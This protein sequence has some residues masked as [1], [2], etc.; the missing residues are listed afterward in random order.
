MLR[1]ASIVTLGLAVA[2][3]PGISVAAEE[4]SE[5][6]KQQA[7]VDTA[8]EETATDAANVVVPADDTGNS[9]AVADEPTSSE[10]S[11]TPTEE[12][13]AAS[14]EEV[15]EDPAAGE[16]EVVEEDPAAGEEEVVEEDPAAGEEEVVEEDPAAN[17]EEVVDEDEEEQL[18]GLTSEEI[19]AQMEGSVNGQVSEFDK[20]KGYY[21]LTINATVTNDSEQAIAN[22]YTGV[23][24]PDDIMVLDTDETPQDIYLLSGEETELAIPF[25]EVKAG[26]TKNVSINIPVIGK[27]AGANLLQTLNAYVIDGSYS[28]VGQI[29][30]TSNL[31]FSTMSEATFFEGKAQA[32]TD[33]PGLAD[34]QFGM[35][36]GFK[37]QNLQIDSIDNVKI[38]FI[39]PNG[40]TIHEPDSYQ[41]GAI[42]DA[43][44][45]FLGGGS[46]GLGSSRLNLDWNGNTA[47]VDI[48]AIEAAGGYQG[49]FSAIGESNLSFEDIKNLK[50]KITLFS[51][52]EAVESFTTPIELVKYEGNDDDSDDGSDNGSGNDSGDT[53]NGS[54]NDGGTTPVVNKPAPT[55]SDKGNN[56]SNNSNNSGKANDNNDSDLKVTPADNDDDSDSEQ[57]GKLPKTAGTNPVG[58]LMG[59]AIAAFGAAL[60]AVRKRLFQ[61]K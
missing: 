44:D 51:G 9:E 50:V 45:D 7:V 6:V 36:F 16:E 48:G 40:V 14:E 41:E 35:Q 37:V 10:P 30:G 34:N 23:D 58:V 59:G 1:K 31:S 4:G 2:I 52:N 39:V 21:T 19:V 49:F 32:V 15:V 26:E 20:E 42:P 5:S 13:P 33:F 17:E 46:L 22:F 24:I 54:D 43:L 25:G 53:D 18:P 27:T 55:N 11:E 29:S 38:E 56:S 3:T 61:H 12:N 57:G 28:P 47:F 60:L 8:S